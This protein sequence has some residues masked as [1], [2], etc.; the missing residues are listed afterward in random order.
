M[1]SEVYFLPPRTSVTDS[2]GISTLPILLAEAECLHPRFERL[3]HLALKARIRVDD[4][5]LH[6]RIARR[7]GR[8]ERLRRRRWLLAVVGARS[9]FVLFF[10]RHS[11]FFRIR[12]AAR[13]IMEHPF[14]AVADRQ[15]HQPEIKRKQEHGDDH[16]R[17]RSLDFLARRRRDFLHLRTYIVVEG[18]DAFRPGPQRGW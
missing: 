14:E 17:R 2:V 13:E 9:A 7:F 8:Q 11:R 10:I 18:L 15:I 6:I 12:L 5:P 1:R 16:H 4:V 3:L